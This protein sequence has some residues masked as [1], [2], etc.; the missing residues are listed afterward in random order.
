MKRLVLTVVLLAFSTSSQAESTTAKQM[1]MPTDVGEVVLTVEP[2][3][4][5]PH[6]GFPYKAYATEQGHHPHH[7]CWHEPEQLPDKPKIS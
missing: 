7:G 5:I 3:E 4:F 2:C 6:H 1:V